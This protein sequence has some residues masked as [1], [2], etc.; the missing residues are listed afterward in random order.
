[1]SDEHLTRPNEEVAEQKAIFLAVKQLRA[2]TKYMCQLDTANNIMARCNKVGNKLY[3][4]RA[5]GEHKIK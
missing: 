2:A 4:L 3:R 1:V 5:Q